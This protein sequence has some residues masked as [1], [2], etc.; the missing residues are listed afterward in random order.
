MLEQDP[1]R[2]ILQNVAPADPRHAQLAGLIRKWTQQ[3]QLRI[4]HFG[5]A[6]F[7]TAA[8]AEGHLQRRDDG[9]EFRISPQTRALWALE[10]NHS[11]FSVPNSSR[12]NS[13]S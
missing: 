9:V 7:T 13:G 12:C 1:A 2:P 11:H 3:V 5:H 6:N 8:L 10:R 4:A